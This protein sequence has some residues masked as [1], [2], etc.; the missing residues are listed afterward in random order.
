MTEDQAKLATAISFMTPAIV[1]NK[2]N[3]VF[4][5][6]GGVRLTFLEESVEGVVHPRC[7][8]FMH[9][10]DALALCSVMYDALQPKGSIKHDS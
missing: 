4:T 9:R 7:T 10:D 1:T 8:V 5:P 6:Q 3:A 2:F